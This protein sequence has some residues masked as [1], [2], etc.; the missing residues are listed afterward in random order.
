MEAPDTQH[1]G[2]P[3]VGQTIGASAEA[4]EAAES[5][6]MRRVGVEEARRG[7]LPRRKLSD[8]QEREVTRLYA[9]TSTPTPEIARR[10]GIAE[11]SVYRVSQRHGAPLRGR[12]PG[13]ARPEHEVSAVSAAPEIRQAPPRPPATPGP[14]QAAPAPK[15]AARRPGGV[16]PGVPKAARGGTRSFR[17]RFQAEVVFEAADIRDALRQAQARGISEVTAVTRQD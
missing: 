17:V 2:S 10:F 15:A 14:P 11:S 16:R 6:S 12:P 1:S 8:E 5:A 3:D 4:D 7:V 9:E 13:R